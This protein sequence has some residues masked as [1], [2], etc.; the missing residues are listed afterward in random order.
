VCQVKKLQKIKFEAIKNIFLF[1]LS[2]SLFSLIISFSTLNISQYIFSLKTSLL[3]TL[4]LLFLFNFVRNRKYLNVKKQKKFFIYFI[5]VIIISRFF[6]YNVFFYLNN[7][8][9]NTNISWLITIG[10]S[11]FIKIILLEFYKKI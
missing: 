2:N 1:H 9:D 3:L 10:F 7:T 4:V 8:F 5:F 6:E 11:F